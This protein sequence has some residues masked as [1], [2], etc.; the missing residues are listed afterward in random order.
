MTIWLFTVLFMVALMLLAMGAAAWEWARLNG[1]KGAATYAVAAACLA[2]CCTTPRR[3]GKA[4]A[5]P[6]TR[7]VIRRQAW[8]VTS[9]RSAA[10]ASA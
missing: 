2:L 1:L 4:T 3:L 10:I 9:V 8:H 6:P 5:R 7:A